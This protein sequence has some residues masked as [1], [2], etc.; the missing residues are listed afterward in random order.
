M[1]RYLAKAALALT[2]LGMAPGGAAMA[3]GLGAAVLAGDQLPVVIY[4]RPSGSTPEAGI[5]GS[6]EATSID[7][8]IRQTLNVPTSQVAGQFESFLRSVS[9][10]L[11][12]AMPAD[13]AFQ[14]SEIELS[15][16]F[17]ATTGFRLIGIAEAGLTSAIRVKLTP[18]AA[19]APPAQRS[20]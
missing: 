12:A 11:R 18:T 13:S 6:P 5:S 7:D 15:V 3:Q 19:P 10:S 9:N 20:P 16:E 14:I 8:A 4:S 1:Q 17:E 2:F